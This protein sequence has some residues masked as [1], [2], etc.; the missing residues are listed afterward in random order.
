[1]K[2][3]A[4]SKTFDEY[5]SQF[6]PRL[7]K[8]RAPIVNSGD[9]LQKIFYLKK[10]YVRL[11]SM[12][13]E[14]KELTLIIFKPG[15]F[16]PLYPA[17]YPHVSYPFWV[18][19]LTPAEIAV[20]PLNSFIEFFKSNPDLLLNL[21]IE[22]MGRLDDALRRM[23]Y[24]AFGTVYTKIASILL[25]MAKNFGK[26]EGNETVID[27]PLTHKDIGLLI[28]AARETISSEIKKLEDSKIIGHKGK[29]LVIKNIKALEKESLLQETY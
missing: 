15:S 5:F 25:V 2:T 10:G 11:Y 20:V 13:S 28:A 27:V 3:S 12:S 6:K 14:G 8:R 21:S 18:E 9:D 4:S 1:M 23:E 19:T 29:L 24:F 26:K 22:I 7:Y 17:L 16:F